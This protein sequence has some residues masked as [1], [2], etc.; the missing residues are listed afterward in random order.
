[1][2]GHQGGWSDGT[3]TEPGAGP[4][5]RSICLAPAMVGVVEPRLDGGA[6]ALHEPFQAH[7]HQPNSGTLQAKRVEQGPRGGIDVTGYVGRVA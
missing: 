7:A 3:G 4:V 2:L 6:L 5:D 1:M